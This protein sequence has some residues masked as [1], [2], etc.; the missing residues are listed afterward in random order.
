MGRLQGGLFLKMEIEVGLLFC[1]PLYF[2]RTSDTKCSL[3][4]AD[5]HIIGS[6]L[7]LF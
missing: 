2:D 3:K 6:K 7:L 5:G 1:P 4:G